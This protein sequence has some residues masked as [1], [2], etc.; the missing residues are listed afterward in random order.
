M[1][2]PR[3]SKT[4]LDKVVS[5]RIDSATYATWSTLARDSDLTIGEWARSMLQ[6]K[7]KA[8]PVVRR[9]TPPPVNPAL[10]AAVGRCGNNLNQIARAANRN[11]LD[12]RHVRAVIARLIDIDRRLDE[13][14]EYDD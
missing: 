7:H 12:N 9:R 4:Q 10:Q 5:V 11:E 6:G 8:L 2:R 14:L 1:A 13:V 3:K